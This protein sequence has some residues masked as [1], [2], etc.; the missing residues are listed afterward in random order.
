MV[1]LT[2]SLS[3]W[4]WEN[5]RDKLVYIT[6]GH[7]E[8]LTE[9]MLADYSEWLHSEEGKSYLQGGKNYE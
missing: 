7:I 2:R 9:D 1:K 8:L 3:H 4:L 6:M 5:H